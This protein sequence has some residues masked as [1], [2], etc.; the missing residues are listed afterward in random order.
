MLSRRKGDSSYF[1]AV[2]AGQLPSCCTVTTPDI[3][4]LIT[5]FDLRFLSQHIYQI[6][7]RDLR[8]FLT[9]EPKPV[10]HVFTP[11]LS[12]ENIQFIVMVGDNRCIELG[13]CR[14]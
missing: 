14:D 9:V 4:Y 12:I 11:Q 2:V 7:Y 13:R 1:G 3:D 6:T 10:M 8:A 5:R